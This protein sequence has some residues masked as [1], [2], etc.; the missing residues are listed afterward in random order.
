MSL[1]WLPV[2]PADKVLVVDSVKWLGVFPRPFLT[3]IESSSPSDF[4]PG[5]N[6]VLVF[7]VRR[8]CLS[9]K[10]SVTYTSH[11]INN[12]LT[13]VV[14]DGIAS[15]SKNSVVTFGLMRLIGR[16]SNWCFWFFRL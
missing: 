3:P 1:A 6:S 4:V 13:T 14:S 9:K 7:S 16:C 15:V 10:P 8:S 12:S 2:L 5:S 11:L